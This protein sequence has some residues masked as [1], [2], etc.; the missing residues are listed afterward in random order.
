M[1]IQLPLSVFLNLGFLSS[2]LLTNISFF[3]L[4]LIPCILLL[5]PSLIMSS[6]LIQQL[7]TLRGHWALYRVNIFMKY[8]F[9]LWW[10]D[11]YLCKRLSSNSSRVCCIHMNTLGKAIKSSFLSPDKII[12]S[13]VLSS[14]G[15]VM[16]LVRHLKPWRRQMETNP[17]LRKM[18]IHRY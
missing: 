15:K 18:A 2:C 3:S 17:L 5:S 4:S 16:S 8:Y 13:T 7:S 1:K 6:V 12:G 14:L 9:I 11:G 10:N